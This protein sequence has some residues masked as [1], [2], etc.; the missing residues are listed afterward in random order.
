MEKD[1][2]WNERCEAETAAAAE[3]N[4]W[5]VAARREAERRGW[6]E[7]CEAARVAAAERNRWVATARQEAA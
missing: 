3:R 5:V 6:S 2:T 4:R 7:H 1:K